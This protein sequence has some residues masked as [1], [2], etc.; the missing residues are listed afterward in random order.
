[1]AGRGCGVLAVLL[2]AACFTHSA[3]AAACTTTFAKALG[4]FPTL[5]IVSSA[6]KALGSSADSD[7]FPTASD[8][9]T[10]LAPSDAAFTAALATSGLTSAEIGDK[11]ISILLYHTMLQGSFAPKV[12][13]AL[14]SLQT[15]LGERLTAELPLEFTTKAAVTKVAGVKGTAKL[16]TPILVCNSNVFIIDAVLLPTATVAKVPSVLGATATPAATPATVTRSKVTPVATPVS[17][18]TAP[19]GAPEA[20]VVET[21]APATAPVAAVAPVSAVPVLATPVAVAVAP[22]TSPTTFSPSL[23]A[24]LALAPEDSGAGAFAA[25]STASVLACSAA[26]VLFVL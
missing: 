15:A 16:G 22:V 2:I 25:L 24:G 17:T 6:I 7:I 13:G 11:A 3:Q 1:M 4:A 12:L 21:V 14:G 19:A 23:L 10:L 9:V 8:G 18:T 5:S 20:A 26:I